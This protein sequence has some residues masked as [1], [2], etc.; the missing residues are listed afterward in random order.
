M[1]QT[2]LTQHG[3]WS[4]FLSSGF[5]FFSQNAS[6]LVTEQLPQLLQI[7]QWQFLSFR[8]MRNTES[9]VKFRMHAHSQ[10]GESSQFENFV[11]K[12]GK[13]A[14]NLSLGSQITCWRF[15]WDMKPAL[16]W[17]HCF[18]WSLQCK[19]EKEK[20]SEQKLFPRTGNCKDSASVI[21]MQSDFEIVL[22]PRVHNWLVTECHHCT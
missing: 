10:W 7:S 19:K 20:K 12:P 6:S 15:L 11:V 13:H 17:S 2:K 4:V 5:N 18:V 1:V 14:C 9:E 8:K 22:Q 21:I 16:L 3:W